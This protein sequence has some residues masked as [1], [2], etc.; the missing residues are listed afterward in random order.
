MCRHPISSSNSFTPPLD[1]C[2][3]INAKLCTTPVD[4]RPTCVA[5]DMPNQGAIHIC[6]KCVSSSN[7]QPQQRH[8]RPSRTWSSCTRPFAFEVS[9][10]ISKFAHRI[11]KMSFNSNLLLIFFLTTIL[12]ASQVSCHFSNLC[13]LCAFAFDS[14]R[15]V[16]APNCQQYAT[17]GCH[18]AVPAWGHVGDAHCL[19]MAWN[20][21]CPPPSDAASGARAL[22]SRR[23]PRIG[24]LP[25][26]FKLSP[27]CDL[28][29]GRLASCLTI[30]THAQPSSFSSVIQQQQTAFESCTK[31]LSGIAA[32][33]DGLTEQSVGHC[34]SIGTL[35]RLFK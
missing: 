34:R 22:L 7:G 33:S 29:C 27:Q 35:R 26:R 4:S 10:L 15:V 25:C 31:E 8:Q 13:A 1:S 20:I 30:S 2:P 14:F 16:R 6:S 19:F 17:Q 9:P 3:S 21:L 11:S 5:S 12:S 28:I 24:P 32:A 18:L 23:C